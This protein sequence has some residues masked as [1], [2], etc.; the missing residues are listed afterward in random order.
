M[1][2]STKTAKKATAV[3]RSATK[4]TMAKASSNGHHNKPQGDDE[5]GLRKLMVDQMKDMLWAEKALTKA[6]PKMMKKACSAELTDA[7]AAHLDETHEQVSRIEEAFDSLGL[8]ATT[9]PCEAMKGLLK[10]AE[11]LM[12]EME[13]GSLRDAAIICAA[14]KVE[15]Y[16][17]A[18]Y[19][20][21]KTY[22][23]MLGES[24]AAGLFEEILNEEKN[25][26]ETL[27]EVAQEINWMAEEEAEA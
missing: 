3:K 5:E 22:A 1:A 23:E 16:E 8:K 9:K 17:I 11:E 14:Q 18:T 13:S 6:I 7:L 21:L 20:C 15:H 10:E 4:R 24:E 25:A 2:K 19:G 26:D 27:S 12:G